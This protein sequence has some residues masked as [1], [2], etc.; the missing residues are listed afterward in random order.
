MAMLNN[1]RVSILMVLSFL[2]L[3]VPPKIQRTKSLMPWRKPG[4]VFVV[5]P[6]GAGLHRY[7]LLDFG[8]WRVVMNQWNICRWME[9]Q[10]LW[11]WMIFEQNF[12]LCFQG[13]LDVPALELFGISHYSTVHGLDPSPS[14]SPWR[15]RKVVM[16]CPRCLSWWWNCFIE[17]WENSER[18]LWMSSVHLICHCYVMSVLLG[19]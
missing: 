12:I 11:T 18:S 9:K 6:W 8:G 7:W 19:C 4:E 17:S 16:F 10:F 13:V 15:P 2:E 14:W 5:R 3:C 1:Q